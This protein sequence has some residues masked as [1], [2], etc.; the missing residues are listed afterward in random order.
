M[1][2]MIAILAAALSLGAC[3][4]I[5]ERPVASAPPTV[6]TT[7]RVVERPAPSVPSAAVGSTLAGCT[8]NG[9][10]TSHGGMSCQERSQHRCVNGNWERT[11]LTC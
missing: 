11:V 2:A 8:W 5:I 7:E 9:Q 6:V 4:R 10:Q 3:T 1:K